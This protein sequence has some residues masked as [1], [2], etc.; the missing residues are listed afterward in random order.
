MFSPPD[1][2][3][4]EPENAQSIFSTGRLCLDS[5]DGLSSS[6]SS[7]SSEGGEVSRDKRIRTS[8]N[9]PVEE[10]RTNVEVGSDTGSGSQRMEARC[11]T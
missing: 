8:M 3:F 5:D 10:V 1:V 11:E 4:D 9:Q 6:S 2:D 7:T